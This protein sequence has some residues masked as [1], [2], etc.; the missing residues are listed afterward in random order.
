MG[1]M[2]MQDLTAQ[3]GQATSDRD[4]KSEAKAAALQHKADATGDL[5]DTTGTKEADEKYLQDLTATCSQ[6][7]SDFE[8]RQ[9]LRTQ[10]LEAIEKAI[11]IISSAA[12]K[13]NAEKHFQQHCNCPRSLSFVPMVSVPCR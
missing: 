6:K 11:E 5:Q 12:V 13:G 1:D 2:L 9:E 7:S 10:E 8:S 3:I 4:E